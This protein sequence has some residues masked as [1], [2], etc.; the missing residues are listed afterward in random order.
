[1]LAITTSTKRQKAILK[2]TV[3]RLKKLI[4][5]RFHGSL[6]PT[7]TLTLS[8]RFFWRS[9]RARSILS[10][11]MRPTEK[12]EISLRR[13]QKSTEWVNLSPKLLIQKKKLSYGSTS[14][15]N[16]LIFTR[17]QCAIDFY[18]TWRNCQKR[19]RSV[20]ESLS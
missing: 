10:F 18:P 6:A 13:S 5:S 17:S 8:D 2:Y 15:K 9:M 16:Y 4:R 7:K 1:M 11:R 19:S 3:S 12:E 14:T 20:K